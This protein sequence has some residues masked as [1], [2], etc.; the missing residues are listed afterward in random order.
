MNK[1]F[2]LKYFPTHISKGQIIYA[3]KS[4]KFKEFYLKLKLNII[5]ILAGIL[6]NKFIC[7]LAT[8]YG[9]RS[10]RFVLTVLVLTVL[11]L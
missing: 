5:S 1:S 4:I 3:A 9:S 10:N 8:T 2:K 7:Q 11:H 6:L